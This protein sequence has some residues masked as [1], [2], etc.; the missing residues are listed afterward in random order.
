MQKP[1]SIL[2]DSIPTLDS[3]PYRHFD[4]YGWRGV[5][6][7]LK[8]GIETEND[9]RWTILPLDDTGIGSLCYNNESSFDQ[10]YVRYDDVQW[11]EN[12]EEIER[13]QETDGTVTLFIDYSRSM[14]YSQKI[15]NSLVRSLKAMGMVHKQDGSDIKIKVND[16]LKL[17]NRETFIWFDPNDSSEL[18]ALTGE[19]TNILFT[20][21]EKLKISTDTLLQLTADQFPNFYNKDNKTYTIIDFGQMWTFTKE[22]ITTMVDDALAERS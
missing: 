18:F 6:D 22:A 8:I 13:L 21:A 16:L 2:G 9:S 15:S 19:A 17:L 3:Y 11:F 10:E 4:V 1:E 20:F 14:A 12:T 7:T 5:N